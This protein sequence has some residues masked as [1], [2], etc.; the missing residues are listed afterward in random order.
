MDL[1]ALETLTTVLDNLK[2]AVWS[3]DLVKQQYIYTNRQF[4]EMYGAEAIT[5]RA[6]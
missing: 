3:F 5:G 6:L 4:N 2:D 1:R